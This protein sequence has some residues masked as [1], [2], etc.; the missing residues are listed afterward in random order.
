M[1][2]NLLKLITIAILLITV[3]ATCHNDKHVTNVTLSQY[4]LTLPI[5][6]TATLTAKVHPEG[7]INKNVTWTTNNEEVAT[8]IGLSIQPEGETWTSYNEEE[9][10]TA[11]NGVITAIAEGVA[12]ITVTTEDGNHT[13]QCTVTV[14]HPGESEMIAVEGGTFTMGYSDNE[15][16]EHTIY[17]RPTHEVTL[18][19]FKIAK[20]PV[21]Q[22]Q[23]MAIMDDSPNYFKGDNL[24]VENVSWDDAQLFIS[25]LNEATGKNYR[26]P[27]ES[28]WEYAC[29]GGKS[30]AQNKYSGSNDLNRVGWCSFNSDRISHPVGT[31]APNEL[32]IYDM[33]GNV[34]EWCHDWAAAYTNE[35]KINPQGPETGDY[36][37]IRGGS[38]ISDYL[39]CR[40]SY[41]SS[42][43]PG[44]HSSEIGLR[45]ALQE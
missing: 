4:A 20:Y 5:N 42:A 3:A 30:S 40:V 35:P 27:T 41:R 29:R 7:A 10:A 33:S 36:R 22:K 2:R 17:E 43:N 25:R 45:L 31:K 34:W 13:A 12:L 37:I 15:F 1:K 23:W 19:D 38:Y 28:E 9:V 21:T 32:G 14:I 18:N 11:V 44:E 26:L 39:K 24:P 16:P 6:E 8:V